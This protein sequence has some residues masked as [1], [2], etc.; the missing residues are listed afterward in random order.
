MRETAGFLG[1][2]WSYLA[3]D[4]WSRDY[5]FSFF[6]SRSFNELRQ[7]KKKKLEKLQ[8]HICCKLLHESII[9]VMRDV[10]PLMRLRQRLIM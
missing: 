1:A 5:F 6:L 3:A 7:E 8:D 4:V 10:K 9:M 2:V